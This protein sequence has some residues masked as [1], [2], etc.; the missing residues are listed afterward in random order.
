MQ[1]RRRDLRPERVVAETR[2]STGREATPARHDVGQR[3]RNDAGEGGEAETKRRGE[4]ETTHG[5]EGRSG[6]EPTARS[7]EAATNPRRGAA[8]ERARTEMATE[9]EK[10]EKGLAVSFSSE[11]EWWEVAILQ[12]EE[13]IMGGGCSSNS[14]SK[15][16]VFCG[17]RVLWRE[18]LCAG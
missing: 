2:N 9:R 10:G 16:R 3:S 13:R 11:V 4:A 12:G 14:N 15:I 7:R 18:V 5:E 8:T 17:V 6:N 1:Q